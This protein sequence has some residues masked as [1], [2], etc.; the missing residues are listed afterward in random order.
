M[1]AEARESGPPSKLSARNACMLGAIVTFSAI[2]PI[3]S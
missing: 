2:K 3:K 1:E